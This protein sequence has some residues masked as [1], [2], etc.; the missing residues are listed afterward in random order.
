MSD[1]T[2]LRVNQTPWD[3]SILYIEK[4]DSLAYSFLSKFISAVLI[5]SSRALQEI[6]KKAMIKG[7]Q[8]LFLLIFS[9]CAYVYELMCKHEYSIA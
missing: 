2:I 5:L 6:Q 9:L 1:G 4:S 8:R 7:F 3:P